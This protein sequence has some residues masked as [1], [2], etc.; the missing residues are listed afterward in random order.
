MIENRRLADAAG[1][2]FEV[3]EEV[4]Q[5]QEALRQPATADGKSKVTQS[6]IN[7][8]TATLDEMGLF[9][10][11]RLDGLRRLHNQ[12]IPEHIAHSKYCTCQPPCYNGFDHDW[13]PAEPHLETLLEAMCQAGYSYMTALHP[14]QKP[15]GYY[16]RFGRQDASDHAGF[17]PIS[18]LLAAYRA[19]VRAVL[20]AEEA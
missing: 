17:D 15:R 20:A 18:P 13:M 1:D 9:L 4:R 5:L 10:A 14:E 6:T 2:T 7:Q 3:V 11:E 8:D 16:W 12:R 19:A